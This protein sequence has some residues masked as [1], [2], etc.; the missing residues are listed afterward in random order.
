MG[1]SLAAAS[2]REHVA[3]PLQADFARHRLVREL[4]HARDFDIECVEREQRAADARG[5]K[6]CCE[7]A[8]LVGRA[9]Q[10]LAMIEGIGHRN[11]LARRSYSTAISAAATR[12]PS[13]S[14]M[15]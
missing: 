11:K 3:P 15:L 12:R 4:P 13:P 7:K 14:R 9:H 5:R 6:Q 1:P 8:V 2:L 10:R